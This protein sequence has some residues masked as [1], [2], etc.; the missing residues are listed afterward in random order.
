MSNEALCEMFELLGSA[1]ET[2]Q[3]LEKRF[4]DMLCDVFNIESRIE[5][6]RHAWFIFFKFNNWMWLFGEER[7][8]LG[9][10]RNRKAECGNWR[11]LHFWT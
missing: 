10:V 5:A 4:C 3:M 2:P 7:S 1:A 9:L 11:V 6:K 8:Y